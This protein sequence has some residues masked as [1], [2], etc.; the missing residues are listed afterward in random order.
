MNL[1]GVVLVVLILSPWVVL[2]VAAGVVRR[3]FARRARR[4]GR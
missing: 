4:K 2:L 1:H 3:R